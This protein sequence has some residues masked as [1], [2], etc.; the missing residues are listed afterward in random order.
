MSILNR[1]DDVPLVPPAKMAANRLVNM[2]RQTYNQMVQSYNQGSRI[3]WQNTMGATPSEV[4]A[5]LGTDAKEVFE[6]HYKLG[7]LLASVD[8]NSVTEA[9]SFIGNFI[10]NNDGTV[11]ITE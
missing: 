5:E 4:A 8:P 3:F 6:L 11:T 7:Q 1:N 9:N 2:T 10:M